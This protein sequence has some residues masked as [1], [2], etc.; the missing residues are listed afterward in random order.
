MI[1]GDMSTVNG[2]MRTQE[3]MI[4]G[5]ISTVNGDI[6][7]Q[8]RS[9]VKGNIVIHR[10]GKKPKHKEHKELTIRIDGGSKVNGNIN[11]KGEDANVTVILA[12][13]G[14]VLGEIINAKVIRD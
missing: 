2:D 1:T 10:D 4:V 13:G 3:S 7:V 5:D 14:E 8:E 12:G 9:V 6:D 11:V